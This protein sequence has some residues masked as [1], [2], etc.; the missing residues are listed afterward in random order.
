[1][2]I[3][4]LFKQSIT[5]RQRRPPILPLNFPPNITRTFTRMKHSCSSL[6]AHLYPY[7][8]VTSSIC[9][10]HTGDEDCF[11]LLYNCPFYDVQRERIIYDLT[12]LGVIDLRIESLLFC[13]THYIP[14]IALAIK[15]IILRYIISTGRFWFWFAVPWSPHAVSKQAVHVQFIPIICILICQYNPSSNIWARLTIYLVFSSEKVD[16]DLYWSVPHR[17]PI[18]CYV[19]SYYYIYIYDGMKYL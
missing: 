17:I 7:Y 4:S 6:N 5:V 3:Y 11:H 18:L 8:L 12:N 19:I 9:C 2:N 16:L 13:E 14:E 10:C 1:M 15:R